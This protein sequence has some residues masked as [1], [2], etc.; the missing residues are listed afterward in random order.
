M[1]SAD[2]PKDDKNDPPAQPS[3]FANFTFGQ[4]STNKSFSELFGNISKVD[5]SPAT[6]QSTPFELNKS[7]NDNEVE[8]YEPTA[9]FEPVIPLPDLVDAKTGEEDEDVKF[10]HRAKLLRYDPTTKEWK[11]RGIG[12]MKV[13]L[14]MKDS[15]KARLL[16]RREQIFKLCCNMVITKELQFKKM[17][18]N[19]YSFGGQDFSEGEMRT[20]LLAI[21]FKTSDLI[22][23]FLE[24]VRDVQKK[25]GDAKAPEKKEEKKTESKGF[26]DKFKPKMGSWTCEGCYISNKA[27]VLYC[28][29]CDSPKD[30]TVPKKEAKSLIAPSADAPK[31]SF[32]MP[33][34]AG[35]FSF[36][37]PAA[38]PTAPVI[39]PVTVAPVTNSFSF[40]SSPAPAAITATPSSFSF[41]NTF[42]EKPKEVAQADST[43]GFAFGAAKTF[44]FGSEVKPVEVKAPEPPVI[45]SGDSAGFNFVFKKKSPSKKS[46]GKSRNDS[47]NSEGVE[48]DENDYHE[49]EENQTYFTPVI[50]LPEKIE[51]KTG[52]ENE[53]VLYSHRAKLFRFTDKEWKERGLGDIK[54]LSHRESGKLRVVMRREQIHKICL[55]FFLTDEVDLKP[56]DDNSWTFFAPDFSEGEIEPISFA[57][58]FKTKEIA[59]GFKKAIDGA[60]A[61]VRNGTGEKQDGEADKKSELVKKLS[62]PPKFFDYLNNPECAGCVGCKSDEFVYN[63]KATPD[64][65]VDQKPIPT[66]APQ[67][68]SK[69]KP[70]R[71]SVDKHV[72]FKIA[73]E[74]E[75]SENEKVKSLF[76]S[77]EKSNVFGSGIKKSEASPNIFA[78][79]NAENP[80]STSVFGNTFS[81]PKKEEN[82]IFSSS[83]NTTP[84]APSSDGNTAEP[85]SGGLFGNKTNFSFGGSDNI[86]GG[87][88]KENGESPAKSFAPFAATPAF[89]SLGGNSINK[90]DVAGASAVPSQNIFGTGFKSSFSF[91]ESAKDLNTSNSTPV[92]PDFLQKT[93][94]GGGFAALA[95]TASPGQHWASST[96]PNASG[97]FGLTVKEDFFSKNLTK[98][99]NP[100]AGDTNEETTED[101]YDPHYDPII[102]LPDEIKVSTGEEDEEKIF[103]DRAKLYRYDTNTKE[104]KERGKKS[105]FCSLKCI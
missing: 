92:V 40:G 2:K 53:D 13:L 57:I 90:P 38:V 33:A 14:H 17:N 99:N 64:V 81:T 89:G 83:L 52:E 48:E 44:S 50:P 93:E 43:T 10:V 55:N 3:P 39:M 49:E 60:L 88:N 4:G 72:S 6:A 67:L 86:F 103:G 29:A 96:P 105:R 18:S 42:A 91:V 19:T 21:K 37:M 34:A 63:S 26:G 102:S 100:D 65:K 31:F 85:F 7:T 30:S 94:E 58:R 25:L 47:V 51:V 27:D 54:V 62:L 46:P 68:K 23:N 78:A 11:E 9:Q 22:E 69:P 95:A 84:A 5:T 98:T 97:F 74:K 70:R 71:Q 76:G 20:E 12:E 56:K 82:S 73:E 32:G 35:G 16:M 41:G 36:G 87:A 15:S 28:V 61:S 75:K 59:V 104:W 45:G 24:A 66:E 79:F 80:L 1:T 101:N 77:A 8:N